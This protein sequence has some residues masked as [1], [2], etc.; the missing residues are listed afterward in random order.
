MA[1]DTIR[2][3]IDGT[4]LLKID[5][6]NAVFPFVGNGFM[7]YSGRL[8]AGT[9]YTATNDVILQFDGAQKLLYVS[10][11]EIIASTSNT[12]LEIDAEAS[13]SGVGRQG[14]QV[15]TAATNASSTALQVLAIVE[16]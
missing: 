11:K 2:T 15:T 10:I 14:L 3:Y 6:R 16:I 5:A 13:I 8:V 4:D 7:V 12:D 9:D 1:N